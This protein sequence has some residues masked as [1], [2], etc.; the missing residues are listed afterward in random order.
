MA[1]KNHVLPF[2]GTW[3]LYIAVWQRLVHH[4]YFLEV[5]PTLVLGFACHAGALQAPRFALHAKSE[6]S[7]RH[8]YALSC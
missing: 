1:Y 4:A 5:H 2:G 7:D 6:Q 8:R 3:F